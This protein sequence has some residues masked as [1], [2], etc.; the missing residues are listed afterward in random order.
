MSVYE[1]SPDPVA[2]PTP[3]RAV[4]FGWTA[5]RPPHD[6]KKLIASKV[7][8]R[9]PKGRLVCAFSP[10]GRGGRGRVQTGGRAALGG[11]RCSGV[12]L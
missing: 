1:G 6:W 7:R 5:A 9:T 10:P 2:P 12:F 8:E 4:G 11:Y 3:A